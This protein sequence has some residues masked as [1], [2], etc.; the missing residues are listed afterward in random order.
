[1]KKWI[2]LAF[3]I[4]DEI[5]LKTDSDQLKRILTSIWL[6]QSGVVYELCQGSTSSWHYDFEMTKEPN[7]VTKVTYEKE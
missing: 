3:E 4:G 6:K 7:M 5:Y 2:E 1:M